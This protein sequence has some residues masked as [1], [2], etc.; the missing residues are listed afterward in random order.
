MVAQAA[1]STSH[2]AE[3]MGME[4]RF[5]TIDFAA[6]DARGCLESMC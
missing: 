5:V 3:T 4:A 6:Y 2:R 1:W